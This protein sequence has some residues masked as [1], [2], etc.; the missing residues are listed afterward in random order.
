MSRDETLHLTYPLAPE[1]PALLQ[2]LVRCW[3]EWQAWLIAHYVCMRH[4]EHRVFAMHQLATH[5]PRAEGEKLG[6]E[7]RPVYYGN[8][9]GIPG[10]I[11]PNVAVIDAHGL[12]D[13]VIARTPPPRNAERHMAHDR[14]PFPGYVSC[15]QPNVEVRAGALAVTP[16]T[17]SDSQIRN[18][19]A[20]YAQL[21]TQ[22]AR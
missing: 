5:P 2:P 18:C 20:S 16:R 10:W 4:Q 15:L 21:V 6:W 12:N 8:T 1:F 17:L 19:E 7:E 22:L 14:W 11:L 3:D 13:F 9:V